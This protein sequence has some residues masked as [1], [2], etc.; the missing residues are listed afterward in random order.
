MIYLTKGEFEFFKRLKEEF[1]KR[2][3]KFSKKLQEGKKESSE[4]LVEQRS[5]TKK[6]LIG[7]EITRPY[8]SLDSIYWSW[9]RVKEYYREMTSTDRYE[10][11]CKRIKT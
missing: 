1:V 3:A 9:K 6:E 2:A 5:L 4:R 11:L 10:E 8:R 7:Q